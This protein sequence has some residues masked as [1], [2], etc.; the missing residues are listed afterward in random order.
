M[1]RVDEASANLACRKKLVDGAAT[2]QVR[3]HQ[4]SDCRPG[5][6]CRSDQWRALYAMF[7]EQSPPRPAD[8]LSKRNG[9]NDQ[10]EQPE[11]QFMDGVRYLKRDNVLRDP[12][13]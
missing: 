7:H 3:P 8:A 10:K 5:S 12:E 1:N 4:Q 2:A 13:G 6:L 11:D 9:D